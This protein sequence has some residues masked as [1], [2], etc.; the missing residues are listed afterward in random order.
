MGEFDKPFVMFYNRL[1]K[2]YKHLAKWAR[3][4]G[5]YA[6]R[7]YD[8]DIP[9]FPAAVDIYCEHCSNA[10]FAVL[11]FYES[12]VH[13]IQPDTV[14][15]YL[16]C[17]CAALAISDT[18][19]SVKYRKKQRNNTQYEKISSSG[20]HIVVQEGACLFL[21]NL[22]DY[23]DTGLFLDHRPARLA[24]AAQSREKTVLNL[25]CYTA[26][27]SVHALHGGAR[28]V[29]SVDLSKKYLRWA[30]KNM[31]LNTFDDPSRC[32]FI[33]S[34]VSVFLKQAAL[35]KQTWDI[36][37]CDPPTFSNSKRANGFL[38]INRHWAA[39][40]RQC[41]AVL[42]KDGVLYFSSNSKKLVFSAT[43]LSDSFSEN[44]PANHFV[45]CSRHFAA[46]DISM[47]SIPEDFRNKKIHRLWK[48]FQ[49]DMKNMD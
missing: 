13:R 7:L 10:L 47:K 48:I 41:C 17:I 37:I 34:D 46:E 35:K 5:V 8:K 15:G 44:I 49:I 14:T 12:A 11:T 24:I 9:E 39:L 22:Y 21:V 4:S 29:C 18:A 19:I 28:A 27:F 16:R 31:R 2:R 6:Y 42:A 1:R 3:H 20:K 32:T 40:V 25:F 30:E 23:L 26:A 43:E 38:D 45:Y 33:Q 36:V